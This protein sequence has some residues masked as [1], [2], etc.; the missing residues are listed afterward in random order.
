MKCAICG[1]AE[2]TQGAMCNACR[3][4]AMA[5]Q[6]KPLPNQPHPGKPKVQKAKNKRDYSAK[7]R[8]ARAAK[9]QRLPTG[10]FFFTFWNGQVWATRLIVP[11]TTDQYDCLR[12]IAQVADKI[13]EYIDAHPGT[14]LGKLDI[15]ALFRSEEELDDKYRESLKATKG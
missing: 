4:K 9:K 15:D 10:S 11:P 1:T 13:S 3:G 8:D 2:A 14:F 12:L 6:G 7:G 5:K